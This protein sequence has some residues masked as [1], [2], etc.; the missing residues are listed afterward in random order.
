M[1]VKNGSK[2]DFFDDTGIDGHVILKW[3]INKMGGLGLDLS[4]SG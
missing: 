3:I 2:R 1:V 4:G